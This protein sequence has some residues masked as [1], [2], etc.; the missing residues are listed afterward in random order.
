MG[1]LATVLYGLSNAA[2]VY[3][4]KLIFDDVLSHNIRFR[5]VA[6]AIV[7]LYALKGMG[8]YFST[9]LLAEAGQKAVFDLRCSIYAHILDQSFDFFR[10][11]Y[12]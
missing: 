12:D 9:T 4:I 3:M 7:S 6:I 1:W 11:N 5:E 10:R 2:L 8:A